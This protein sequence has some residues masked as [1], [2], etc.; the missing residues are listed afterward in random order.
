MFIIVL[1]L[2]VTNNI[3]NNQL[4]QPGLLDTIYTVAR[5]LISCIMRLAGPG[6]ISGAG[7]VNQTVHPSGVGILVAISRQLGLDD[8]C[9]ILRMLKRVGGKT[10]GV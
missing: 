7:T 8:H 10:D 4:I 3:F 6:S 9:R 1:Q 5:R 2:Y